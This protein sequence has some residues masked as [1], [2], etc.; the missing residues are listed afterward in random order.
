MDH[1]EEAL[2]Q[3][4]HSRNQPIVTC[5]SSVTAGDDFH[6]IPFMLRAAINASA[7]MPG[8]LLETAEEREEPWMIPNGGVRQD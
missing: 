1:A 5:S 2:G 8:P 4:T 3:P 6:S 7:R